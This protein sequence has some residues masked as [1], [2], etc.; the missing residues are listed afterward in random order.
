MPNAFPPQTNQQRFTFLKH[1]RYISPGDPEQYTVVDGG[2]SMNSAGFV[3][4]ASGSQIGKIVFDPISN[5]WFF[6]L[7]ELRFADL[8][9][10]GADATQITS[11]IAGLAK[12]TVRDPL[13]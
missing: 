7:D 8:S 12:P 6:R 1:S 13:V 10:T 4:S 5:A 2:S 9:I 3:S 11:F